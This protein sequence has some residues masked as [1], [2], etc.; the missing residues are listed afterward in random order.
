[1][2]AANNFA[3]SGRILETLDELAMRPEIG[4]VVPLD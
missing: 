2:R 3:A 1:L 4:A